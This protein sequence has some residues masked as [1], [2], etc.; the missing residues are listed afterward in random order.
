M[1]REDCRIGMK[2][3][4]GRPNG[5][6][7]IG[8]IVYVGTKNVVLNCLEIRGDWNRTPQRASRLPPG[9]EWRVS[10]ELVE[11]LSPRLLDAL[12]SLPPENE[13][14]LEYVSEASKPLPYDGRKISENFIMLAIVHTYL[15]RHEHNK[16]ASDQKLKSLFTALGRPVCETVAGDWC[17]ERMSENGPV[18]PA[19]QS[20]A[21]R[22]ADRKIVTGI[23]REFS[24]PIERV[25][26][27]RERGARPEPNKVMSNTSKIR[28]FFKTNPL[29]NNRD[30][31][32]YFMIRGIDVQP[33]LVSIVKIKMVREGAQS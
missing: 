3:V 25:R 10:H 33:S 18:E 13:R 30:C 28:E 5:E 21:D 16:T 23:L 1:L 12:N 14:L 26:A 22:R 29:A 6:K 8:E 19:N 2:A 4:F 31:I 11:P 32:R 15:D 24:D 9:S 7:T 17:R 27:W 20:E